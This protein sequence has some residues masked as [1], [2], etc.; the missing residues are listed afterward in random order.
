MKIKMRR[1]FLLLKG[2]LYTFINPF[3]LKVLLEQ[4]NRAEIF[5][6][7]IVH[8]DGVSISKIITTLKSEV[9]RVSFDDTSIARQI[10]Q[11]AHNEDLSVG[12]IG[13][14]TETISTAAKIISE[15][16]K[17]KNIT[18]IDGYFD[19]SKSKTDLERFKECD[20]VICSMG[21]PRQENT[22]LTLKELGWNGTGF[23]CGGYFDQLVE[24]KG[25]DYYPA[26]INKLNIRWIYRLYKEP[27][28]LWRRYLI[29][30]P[31][32]LLKLVCNINLFKIEQ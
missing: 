19:A 31:N 26:I 12:F 10:F 22:L 21:T 14:T 1:N 13:S 8:P 29:D 3:S 32:G 5:S 24:A 25:N 16:H 15:R 11:A 30:Y 18:Y 9:T 2:E 4:P 6:K 28:R 27:S 7:F 23:T 20:L 17:I